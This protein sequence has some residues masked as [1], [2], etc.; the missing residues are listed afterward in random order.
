MPDRRWIVSAAAAVACAC[1]PALATQGSEPR[2]ATREPR[3]DY[4]ALYAQGI[5]F[6]EFLEKARARRD[7]WRAHYNAATVSP[8]LITRMRALPERRRI[9][10]VAEDYCLDS[11]NTIPYIARLVD[12]APER[13]ALRMLDSN[14]GQPIMDAH[15]TPDGRAATP[16]IAI[17]AEDGRL[18]ASWTERPSTTQTWFLEQQ[19]VMM[20]KPLH[21]QLEAWYATDAGKTTVAEIADLLSR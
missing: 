16:T 17:L 8:D 20:Q 15:R 14:R 18:R 1:A 2:S 12:G 6:A 10:V 5:T 13:L 21:D 11:A 3:I 9:L 7:E 4:P 19:K